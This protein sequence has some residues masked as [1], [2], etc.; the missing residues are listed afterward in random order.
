VTSVRVL[1]AFAAV[2]LAASCASTS[3]S[4][5]GGDRRLYEAR[6]GVCHVAYPREEHVPAEWPKILDVMGPRAGL[7]RSQRE[8]VLR[9]LTEPSSAAKGRANEDQPR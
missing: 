3:F 7:T 4:G 6:C 5:E 8:R 2:V 9:Y 1:P